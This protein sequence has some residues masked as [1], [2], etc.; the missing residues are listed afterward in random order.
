MRKRGGNDGARV[1]VVFVEFQ[2]Y[3]K[4]K[5]GNVIVIT[6]LVLPVIL[7]VVGGVADLSRVLQVRSRLQDAVD[8]ASIGSIA[9]NSQAY[10]TAMA[11]GNG[12]IPVGVTQAQS[13]FSSNYVVTSELSAVTLAAKVSKSSTIVTSI[14]TVTAN[15]RPYL[16]GLIGIKS[17]PIT[18]TSTSMSSMPPYIDF[19]L[20]LDN[21]PSMGVGA[22]TSDINT[23]VANT[24]DKCAFAC[25]ETDLPGKDYYALAAK[26]G[27]TKRID[28]V[29]QATQNLMTTATKTETLPTQYRVAIY[30]FGVYA[31][32]IDQK[33]PAA[34]QVSALTS[35]LTQSASDA[36]AVDLMIMPSPGYNND[37][38]TNLTSE[39]SSMNSTM[40]TPG[41]GN[42]S[43]SPQEV[44]FMV[45]DGTNDGYDCGYNNGNTCRR[46]TPI[47]TTVCTAI[48]NRGI[49]IA[50]LY[51]TYLPLPTNGF[52]NT[53]LA[54]YVS[55]PSQLAT[56]MQNC[57]S[58]G[59]YFEVSPSQGISSAMTSLFNSVISVV[60][61]SS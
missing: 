45:S 20:L 8:V 22:T 11:M 6:A 25:H 28:V 33:A 18:V 30:D 19:Y 53:Y 34:Y 52:Y 26:L 32:S 48:K 61:I 31:N 3:I 16:L 36:S 60:R 56:A 21:S 43:G 24:S 29:R 59:L 4:N 5:Q 13:I 46:I 51:T 17:L 57:A 58:P 38:Q 10:K 40:P 50:M 7:M 14:V 55:A 2:N 15:Y 47:D 54:K 44:L 35:N 39:L 41:N 1:K 23:M 12:D 27:V 42:G 37:S 49:R 9:V